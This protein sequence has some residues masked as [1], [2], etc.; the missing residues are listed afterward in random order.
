MIVIWPNPRETGS[1][2][3]QPKSRSFIMHNTPQNDLIA[4]F[5]PDQRQASPPPFP[6]LPLVAM[7]L[8]RAVNSTTAAGVCTRQEELEE[9]KAGICIRCSLV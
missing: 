8:F 2:S 9:A 1:P 5:R 4:T 6:G 7:Y 3:H